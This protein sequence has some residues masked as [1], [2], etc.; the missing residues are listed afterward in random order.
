MT[1]QESLNVEVSRRDGVPAKV[2]ST[3]GLGG[4]EEA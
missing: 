1:T 2:G 3:A 4:T